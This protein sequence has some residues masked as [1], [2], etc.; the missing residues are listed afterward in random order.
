M[1][2]M[3]WYDLD[4]TDQDTKTPDSQ[5]AQTAVSENGSQ[6][7]GQTAETGGIY[8]TEDSNNTDDSI[9][10]NDKT[11]ST[12]NGVDPDFWWDIPIITETPKPPKKFYGD[13]KILEVIEAIKKKC[14][15]YKLVYDPTMDT[16]FA[17][18]ILSAKFAAIAESFWFATWLAFALSVIDASMK[19]PGQLYRYKA[20]G[21][22]VIYQKYSAILT[23]YKFYKN[24]EENGKGWW[25]AP[26]A[27]WPIDKHIASFPPETQEALRKRLQDKMAKVHRGWDSIDEINNYVKAKNLLTHTQGWNDLKGT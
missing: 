24:K 11:L 18:H 22:K 7:F 17:K 9:L 20:N 23:D 27:Y 2:Y 25:W 8:N 19:Y 16:E 21:P 5:T 26:I 6:P 12:E 14:V 3:I 13:P 4:K 1:I 15:E 10:S